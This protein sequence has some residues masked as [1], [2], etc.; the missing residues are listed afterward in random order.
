[1]LSRR[2]LLKFLGASLVSLTAGAAYAFGYGP[3]QRPHIARYRLAPR[4][5]PKGHALRIVALS[6]I[7]VV[8]PWM[9]PERLRGI[10]ADANAL[11]PDLVLLLGD[12][13]TGM[14]KFRLD[15]VPAS[16][17][18][19]ALGGLSAP[20]GVHA[21]LG[22][23]DWWDDEEVQR[24]RAGMPYTRRAL[25]EAG[26]RVLHN[27]AV[28]IRH[29]SRGFWLAGLGDQLALPT[30]RRNR[31]QSLADLPATL[32]ACTNDDPVLLMA[33]EPDM[34]PEVPDRVSLTLSGHTHGG[35]VNLF[36][37]RPVVP[38]RFGDR[39][40]YGHIVEEGR[41]LIVSGGLGCSIAPVRVGVAPEIVLIELGAP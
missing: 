33:H 17:W 7:H 1:M 32:A 25:E 8:E 10:V 21:V 36:G 34:F 38:S 30:A 6:D 37:W 41:H 14:R 20:L 24:S 3:L 27:E 4:Q 12:F 15:T 35:Q 28:H 39:F 29:G 19:P 2:T 22:N 18:A 40:A 23:H 26:I 9:N 31:W 13:V 16:A 11:R 5:W